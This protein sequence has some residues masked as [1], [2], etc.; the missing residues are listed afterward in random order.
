MKPHVQ[1]KIQYEPSHNHY[2]CY[3]WR[4]LRWFGAWYLMT[5]CSGT[6]KESAQQALQKRLLE[7]RAPK[8]SAPATETF[9]DV[10][11]QTVDV[12]PRCEQVVDRLTIP[13][14]LNRSAV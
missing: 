7:R 12:R 11:G 4:G 5:S 13:S 10:D 6:T 2:F 14:D 9:Y 3:E 1:F 8:I